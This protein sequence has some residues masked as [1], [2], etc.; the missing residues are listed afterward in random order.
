MDSA[1]MYYTRSNPPSPPTPPV[2]YKKLPCGPNPRSPA[3]WCV[4]PPP[5][6][7]TLRVLGRQL[8]P[9][10]PQGASGQQS[11]AKGAA[12]TRSMGTKGARCSMS[13]KAQRKILSTLPLHPNTILKPN[14]DPNTHPNPQ[15]SPKP[16]PTLALALALTLALTRMVSFSCTG[17]ASVAL[18]CMGKPS[19]G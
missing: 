4:P 8:H 17:K 7:A 2:R 6:G 14:P 16:T 18:G 12:L 10:P 11:V 19:L 1:L 5:W 3:A 13:T 15:P 9:P